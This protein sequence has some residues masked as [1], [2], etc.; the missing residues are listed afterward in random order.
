[1]ID[2]HAHVLA[3]IDDGP[4]TMSEAVETMATAAR[5]G[6]V[7]LAAT[8]HV[9]PDHPAVRPAEL[10]TRTSEL[11]AAC[12]EAGVAVELVVGGE[13]DL[14]WAQRADDGALAAASYGGQGHDLLVETPYSELPANFEE[15]VL[16]VAA[17]GYRV[18]LAHPERNP[19]LQRNP[20][21]LATLLEHG[22]LV[23]VTAGALLG[24]RSSR[25]R[26]LATA[27]MQ[28]RQAHVLASDRHGVAIKRTGLRDGVEAADREIGAYARWMV[29]DAPAA[30]LAGAPLPP[31]PVATR[32]RRPWRRR[33]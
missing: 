8:P 31:S 19:T 33:A 29:T 5:E 14:A 15:L 21:R 24:P 9:R 17:R 11:R 10:A 1:M 4:A 18:L 16:R 30:I 26:R 23:Q 3:G 12:A 32:P 22:T 2:L 28:E 20:R 25:S 6:V 13:V 27:L 7:T